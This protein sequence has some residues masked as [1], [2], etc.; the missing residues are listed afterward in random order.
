MMADMMGPLNHQM[1]EVKRMHES[2]IS[3]TRAFEQ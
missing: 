3:Y 2:T 1:I